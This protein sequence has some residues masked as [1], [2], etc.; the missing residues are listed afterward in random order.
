MKKV[1]LSFFAILLALFTFCSAWAQEKN[2]K[3][4]ILMIPDGTSLATVSS[5]R[6]YQRYNNPE[7][8]NLNIDPYLCGTVLTFSSN[9]PIGD[10]AP[11][12]SCFMTGIPS[13]AGHVSTYPVADSENDIIPLDPSMAYQPLITVLEAARLTQNKATG[14]VFTC[15]FPHATPADCAAHSYNRGKYNWIAPQMV[16]NGLDVVI[17]GGASLF[18]TPMKE[19][20]SAEGYQ[21]FLNDM[22][23]QSYEGEKMWALFNEKD[24]DYEIDRNPLKEPSIAEMTT[25]AIEL[26][27][28]NENGFFLM[29]EGS[30]IDWAA[31]ANDAAAII[32]DMLA[33]DQACGVAFDFAKENGET[34]VVIVPD[35]GN[36]GISIGSRKCPGYTTL[37]KDQLFANISQFKTSIPGLIAKLHDTS[38]DK[39]KDVVYDLTGIALSDEE[40]EEILKCKDYNKSTVSDEERMYGSSLTKV[41]ANIL[42]KNTCFGFTTTGHTGEEV[43]L[44]VYDPTPNRLMGHKTNVE[45]NHYLCQSLALET[46]L[47]DLTAEYFSKHT[48]VFEGYNYKIET[49]KNNQPCLTVKHKKNKLEIRPNTNIILKNGKEYKLDTVI[50]YVDKNDTFYL[51]QSLRNVTETI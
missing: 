11:T 38:P 34:I 28:K 35:H 33:F 51:P 21:C 32:H 13:R 10:S 23:F 16:H 46:N 31:H 30:K 7:I 36:S 5:A 8:T 17:G 49:D 9:A 48:T 3:N 44:A 41:V 27:S 12:T 37:T 42:D 19:Y 45:L 26:L 43:F 22:N 2:I 6:W 50:I 39:M 14:L 25:K 24:M 15:E 18:T 29:V 20:L 1:S 4:V 40:Y 47:Q